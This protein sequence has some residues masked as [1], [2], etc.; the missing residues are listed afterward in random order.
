MRGESEERERGEGRER[1]EERE[2]REDRMK[3][4]RKREEILQNTCNNKCAA[5]CMLVISYVYYHI[6]V[7]NCLRASKF[8][9]ST[10]EA[11]NF[12]QKE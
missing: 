12:E 9:V 7:R 1:K 10:M 2:E 8:R 5:T 11:L 4:E 3:G 6:P